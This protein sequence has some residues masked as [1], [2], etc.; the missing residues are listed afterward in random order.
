VRFGNRPFL[1]QFVAVLFDLAI[2]VGSW[3][4]WQSEI[5]ALEEAEAPDAFYQSWFAAQR[6]TLAALR[7]DAEA[8]Q[9]EAAR[10]EAAAA[11]LESAMVA[12]A[13]AMNRAVRRFLSADWADASRLALEAA[14]DVNYADD[15][16]TLA[17]HAA[18]AGDLRD[19]LAAAIDRLRISPFQ[20]RITKSALTAAQAGLAAR[21]GR[22]D[23]ARA[24]YRQAIDTLEQTGYLLEK[25]ITSL[26]WGALGGDRDP[27]AKA[28]G[29]AG[30]A[31]F[32]VRDAGVMVER[33][34]AAFVPVGRQAA[35]PSATSPEVTAPAR[36]GATEG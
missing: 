6:A 36:S 1:Q 18:V 34:R 24:G 5:E 21:E 26:E 19:D 27:E 23:E 11:T 4:E 15:A 16:A 12:A 3:G 7:G 32:V 28:A 29:A 17:A 2:R 25:A 9:A 35:T 13:V 8:A 14:Q 10:M 33:Y 31:F 30:E 20:G 22:W